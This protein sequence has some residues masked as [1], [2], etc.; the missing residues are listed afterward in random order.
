MF[1]SIQLENLDMTLIDNL[2][3]DYESR[4]N[5]LSIGQEKKSIA[6]SNFSLWV[7]DNLTDTPDTELG[8][9]G[10]SDF[11]SIKNRISRWEDYYSEKP[12]DCP[13]SE[14]PLFREKDTVDKAE[15]GRTPLHVAIIDNN[16]DEIK[17]LISDGADI[18]IKDNGGNTAIELAVLE[19]REDIVE[20]FM[21]EGM[22]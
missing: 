1:T 2:L 9:S 12:S 20:W 14:W 21:D 10:L 11:F 8:G 6:I 16:L 13:D 15:F 3:F 17:K 18:S 19:D 5:S 4:I 7:R 22:I